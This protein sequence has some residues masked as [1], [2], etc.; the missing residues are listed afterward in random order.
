MGRDL[1]FKS[2]SHSF[3]FN[4]FFLQHFVIP[5]FFSP[6]SHFPITACLHVFCEHCEHMNMNMNI[7][8]VHVARYNKILASDIFEICIISKFHD[9]KS[10]LE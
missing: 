5:I 3:L 2:V 1:Y 7:V 9:E 4:P 8:N 6:K 10:K